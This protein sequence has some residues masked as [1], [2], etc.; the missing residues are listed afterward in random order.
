MTDLRIARDQTLPLAYVGQRSAVLGMSGSGKSNASVV[1]A[2]EMHRAGAPWV[3]IDPKG[4]WY[5]VRSS[6]DGKGPGLDVPVI[7]GEYGDLPLHV[8]AGARLGELAAVGKLRGVIDTSLFESN[9]DQAR[10]MSAF[11]RA[12][13][14]HCKTPIHVFCDECDEYMP[15]PG[16]GGRLEG[17]AAEC[18]HVW[19]LVARRGRS[20][21][22]GF[23]LASQRTALV[24]KTCLYQCENLIAMRMVG[25]HDKAAIES[26]LSQIGDAKELL[27]SLPLL[28]DGEG[29]VWSPQ[30]LKIMRRVKFRRRET[31]DS[32]RTPEVA[33]ALVRANFPEAT[34]EAA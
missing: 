4:D 9:A 10:F 14:R 2:E 21:G 3:A 25:K 13:L 7:G 33:E 6:R 19:K 17:P 23:T 28:E 5:G 15:Q 16:S 22:I 32:G 11:G 12:L 26:W 18:V 20:K 1:L 27:K 8:D 34:R 24:N 30:R 29:W 31:F